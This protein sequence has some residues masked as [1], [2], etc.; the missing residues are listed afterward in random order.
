MLDLYSFIPSRALLD[1]T[2]P[3]RPH[4]PLGTMVKNFTGQKIHG[5]GG[6]RSL[7]PQ[8]GLDLIFFSVGFG[9]E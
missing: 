8:E 2:P 4:I 5:A 3:I 7:Q 6:R 9:C 1:H